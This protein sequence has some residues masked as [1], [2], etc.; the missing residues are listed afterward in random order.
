MAKLYLGE[1][2]DIITGKILKSLLITC[3][4]GEDGTV[5]YLR[6]H[7]AVHDVLKKISLWNAQFLRKARCTFELIF[8]L[9]R[10]VILC[11]K[12]G[13]LS[14]NYV[15]LRPTSR[16]AIHEILSAS[17]AAR[18][19]MANNFAH[20]IAPYNLVSCLWSTASVCCDLSNPSEANLSSTSACNFV[21]WLS[22][23][24][25]DHVLKANVYVVHGR[26]L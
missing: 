25:E 13:S 19:T 1:A 4:Y 23:T 22:G 21:Q 14:R 11:L 15:K 17:F 3:R 16:K 9:N 24:R 8:W 6:V 26:E 18:F 20:S 7:N 2:E 10:N 5:S 12:T